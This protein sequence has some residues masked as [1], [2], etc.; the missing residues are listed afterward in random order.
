MKT[1]FLTFIAAFMASSAIL[2]A[3]DRKDKT[4]VTFEEIYDEPYSVNKLFVGF[5]PLY[6]EL[7]VANVNAGFGLEAVYYH[8]DKMDLRAHFRKTYSRSFF[9]FSRDMALSNS[10]ADNHAQVYNYFEVG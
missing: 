8:Q 7:S 3:Q 6:G 10:D 2:F 9:D 1:N 5:Q 4:P